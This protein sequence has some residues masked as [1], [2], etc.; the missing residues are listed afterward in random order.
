MK[1]LHC[2]FVFF[3]L[4]SQIEAKVINL[5]SSRSTY[6]L[7]SQIEVLEDLS[8]V[9]G[10]KDIQSNEWSERFTDHSGTIFLMDQKNSPVYWLRFQIENKSQEHRWFLIMD[11]YPVINRT[12]LYQKK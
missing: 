6:G 10:I 7:A 9:L 5:D 12:F 4:L 2:S 3:C 1:W 11:G 8:G